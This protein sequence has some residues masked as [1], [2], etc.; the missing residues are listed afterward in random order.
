VSAV[1]AGDPIHVR[2]RDGRIEARA[3]R[4]TAE[5]TAREVAP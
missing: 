1:A 4:I 5:P 2:L 3:E